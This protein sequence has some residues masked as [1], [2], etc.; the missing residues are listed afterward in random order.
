MAQ[1]Y[2]LADFSPFYAKEPQF[3]I[4]AFEQLRRPE[5]LIWPHTHSFFE[6][7][8]IKEGG[9]RHKIDDHEIDLSSD[10][11]YF[12]S[13]GQVH[14]LE[15]H[16]AVKGE[17]IMFT[18]EFFITNFTNREALDKLSFL[19]NSYKNPHLSIDADTKAALEPVIQLMHSEFAREQHSRLALSSLLFV[20]LNSLERVYEI[21]KNTVH[22]SGQ[23]ELLDKFNKLLDV[24][25]TSQKPLTFYASELFVTPQYLNI[26]IKRAS[27]KTAGEAIRDRVMLEAKRLLIHTDY[28][29]GRVADELGFS[30]FSYFCRRFKE[31]NNLTPEQYRAKIGERA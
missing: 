13:P 11:I 21:Q 18:E 22:T 15:Q 2:H 12:I 7:L 23:I 29:I 17:S 25:Y 8:W 24:N 4:V 5:P 31:Y 9:T 28:S 14:Q 19:R 3:L 20:L 27:G 30:D 26:V 16:T 10:T 6:I 1:V